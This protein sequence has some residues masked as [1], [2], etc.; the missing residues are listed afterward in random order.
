MYDGLSNAAYQP[1]SDDDDGACAAGSGGGGIF[2][3]GD[4]PDL[5]RKNAQS[6]NDVFLTQTAAVL[7]DDDCDDAIGQVRS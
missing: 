7:T 5:A 1:P 2:Y 6:S 3:I 4:S